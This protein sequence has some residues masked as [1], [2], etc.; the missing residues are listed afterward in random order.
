M[1]RPQD[2][3]R[4]VIVGQAHWTRELAQGLNASGLA[5]VRAVD[6]DTIP[7]ALGMLAI[8]FGPR[9]DVVVRM[10]FRPGAH[11]MRGR[12]FDLAFSIVMALT[13]RA[14]TAYFWIGTDVLNAL[15]D[16]RAGRDMSRFHRLA[17]R[18]THVADAHSLAEELAQVG[19]RASVAW[20][21][22]RNIERHDGTAPLPAEFSVLTYIPDDRAAF[23]DGPTIAAVARRMPDVTF[24]VAT[25]EGA[26]LTDKP[27]NLEFLGW[28]EDFSA[29]YRE[30]SCL[31]RSV[32]HDGTSSMVMESLAN[33]RPVIYSQP[34]PHTIRIPFGDV[35][36]IERAIRELKT[37]Q[38]ADPTPDAEA[39]RWALDASD[40][41]RCYRALIDAFTAEVA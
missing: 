4:L 22:A 33:G 2:T 9:P 21:P 6:I 39:T 34:F 7:H 40:P 16:A 15:E 12:V 18:A 26:W 20:M 23:Y 19:V 35:D 8:P 38:A 24:R 41:Q 17:R 1:S 30:S 28:V 27:D 14:R 32:E 13:P 37:R 5:Q 11:T 29:L 36:S 25:G 3:P 10:G 31:L